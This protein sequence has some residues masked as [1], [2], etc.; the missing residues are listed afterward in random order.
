MKT[1][2]I[3]EIKNAFKTG[4]IL[5]KLIYINVGVWILVKAI[6]LVL[7]LL[8]FQGPTSGSF[9]KWLAVPADLRNLVFKPWT[10]FTYMFLHEGFM[11]IL[12]NM[13]WLFWFGKIFI[14]YLGSRKLLSVY[15]LGGMAGAILYI[16][17]F[18]IFPVFSTVLPYSYALGASASVL[19]I[20]IATATYIPNYSIHLM[21]I[22]PVKIKYI[23]IFS[24][25]LDVLSIQSGNAGGHI[26]HLGG[27]VFGYFFVVKY[28]NGQDFSKG[29]NRFF[30]NLGT[31]FLKPDN[32]MHVAYSSKNKTNKKKS[33]ADYNRERASNQR[34]MD[35][36]L[37]K[38]SKSGYDSLSKEEKEILFKFSNKD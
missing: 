28:R 21:F 3:D 30:Q 31:Y 38:I 17:A 34:K 37:D 33:D 20:V 13:L 32:D 18:N 2:V 10:F 26:A 4:D 8:N 6:L 5:T 7:F 19:A 11:H 1:T 16:I 22:G 25:V 9:I 15:I 36:I 35:E 24:V 29:F 23:A 27:A 12:F 14:E